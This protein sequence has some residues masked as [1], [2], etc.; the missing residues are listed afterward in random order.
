MFPLAI[1]ELCSGKIFLI[2]PEEPKGRRKPFACLCPV[3]PPS[4][5]LTGPIS[6]LKKSNLFSSERVISLSLWAEGRG[7]PGFYSGDNSRSLGPSENRFREIFA[8]IKKAP[9]PIAAPSHSCWR[10]FPCI[11]DK[12]PSFLFVILV[13][14]GKQ[15]FYAMIDEDNGKE[16]VSHQ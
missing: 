7:N 4:S 9:P 14:I 16:I 8:P 1:R 3:Y 12:L 5:W 10:A 15:T 6:S 11:S 2:L 13:E